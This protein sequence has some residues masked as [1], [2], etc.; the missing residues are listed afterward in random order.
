MLHGRRLTIRTSNPNL[1]GLV[2]G[3]RIIGEC[4]AGENTWL[5]IAEFTGPGYVAGVSNTATW[6][7]HADAATVTFPVDL[8]SRADDCSL[9][10]I[11]PGLIPIFASDESQIVFAGFTAAGR[12]VGNYGLTFETRSAANAELTR[13]YG[14]AKL[15]Q[16]KSSRWLSAAE[17]VRALS[18][19][20]HAHALGPVL[21]A[22]DLHHVNVLDADFVVSS[23][24]GAGTIELAVRT[25]DLGLVVRTGRLATAR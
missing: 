5:P 6:A 4:R 7:R 23:G 2:R 9:A 21:A 17:L 19:R 16:A 22:S 20:A 14:Q 13:A 1:L 3:E 24:T 10:V 25:G 18:A 11:N 15:V 12:R 8:S